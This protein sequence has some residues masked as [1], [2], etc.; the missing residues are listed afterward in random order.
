MRTTLLVSLALT[1]LVPAV[2]V[3]EGSAGFNGKWAAVLLGRQNF[4]RNIELVITDSGGT[5]KEF[6]GRR[7]TKDHP[8]LDRD[9]PVVI[10]SRD[11]SSIA[12]QVKASEA[13][14]GCNDFSLSVKSVDPN[15]LEGTV[16]K[17]R[18]IKLTR[19]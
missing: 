16:G 4:E 3:A 7:R 11:E 9:F 5:W 17:Q 6:S 14:R 10:L 2:S 18:P 1:F 12:L 8:C 15:T 19:Q 13:L